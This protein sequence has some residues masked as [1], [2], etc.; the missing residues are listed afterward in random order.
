[1]NQASS[2]TRTWPSRLPS[3]RSRKRAL[4][5]LPRLA[6]R[7]TSRSISGTAPTFQSRSTTAAR[8]SQPW[9]RRKRGRLG[10]AVWLWWISEPG[11]R[12]EIR[13]TTVSSITTYQTTGANSAVRTAGSA[14]QTASQAQRPY[15]MNQ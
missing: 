15:S 12:A 2:R 11:A 5:N 6:P 4:L 3:K 8:H 9:P 14:R 10:L 7:R 13:S 1:M